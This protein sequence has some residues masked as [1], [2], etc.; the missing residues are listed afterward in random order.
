MF[1][2]QP[3]DAASI[4]GGGIGLE[5]VGAVTS[6]VGGYLGYQA[7][8]GE[9]QAQ[10]NIASM[11]QQINQLHVTGME[12]GARRNSMEVLRNE[13]KA[14]S[15]ALSSATNQGAAFG[16]GLQGGYGQIAGY[17][18]TNLLGIAQ[19]LSL[20]K[21]E[22]TIQGSI[23]QQQLAASKYQSQAATAQGISSLG[24]GI[25]SAGSSIF[26]AATNPSGT[27]FTSS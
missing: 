9:Y 16:S 10:S 26:S 6:L 11:Q 25:T 18:G 15:L 17:G 20:G 12:L 5:G 8:Q 13:Q 23:I 14:R 7:A 22:A 19:N 2:L 4:A 21:Q 27:L 24:G 3:S 1:G